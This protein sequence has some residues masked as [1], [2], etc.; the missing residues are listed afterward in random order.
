MC[1]SLHLSLKITMAQF[2]DVRR[3][4]KNHSIKKIL[5]VDLTPMVD[6][7]FLL[8]TFFIL[9]TSLSNPTVAR[10]IMPKDTNL[11]T[12]VKGNAVLTLSLIRNNFIDY[13]EGD[14]LIPALVQHCSFSGLRSVIQ[15]KQQKVAEVLSDRK[16]TVIIISPGS[17]STYK[18]LV[19]VL[20]EIQINDIRYYFIVDAAKEL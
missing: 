18:N 12:P 13:Y 20:D 5:R 17:G 19:D 8:I 4:S 2:E 9:T 10:L 3:K 6:L 1:G 16:E 14:T 15:R 7:G 11:T